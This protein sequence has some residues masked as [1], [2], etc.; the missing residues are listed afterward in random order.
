[1][2]VEDGVMEAVYSLAIRI[3]YSVAVMDIRKTSVCLLSALLTAMASI[4]A[5]YPPNLVDGYAN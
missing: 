4:L 5:S 3:N 1:M 2:Q